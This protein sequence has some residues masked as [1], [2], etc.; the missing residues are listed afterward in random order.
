MATVRERTVDAGGVPIFFREWGDGRP[1]VL[2]HGF[3]QTSRCW[4]AVAR[5]LDGYRVL[6]PDIP[7]CGRS[8]RPRS[9]DTRALA[10]TMAAFMDA[11]G[12]PRATV[13][14]HD[15]GGAVAL[16]MGLYRPDAVERLCIVNSPYG[17][18]DL[19]HGWHMLLFNIPLLPELMFQLTRGAEVDFMLK[20]AAAKKDAF[21]PDAIAEYR[22]AYRSL[23][24][25]RAALAYYRTIT[26]AT[27]RRRL[28]RKRPS[29]PR[30]RIDMP[31]MVIWGALDPA[32]PVSLTDGIARRNPD[33]RIEKIAG[34]G[35]FVPEEA[36]E[37]VAA[38]LRD[39]LS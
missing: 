27:I 5:R 35:H 26:R 7:G 36:P 14:G 33:A 25:Q 20:R 11:A 31:L 10:E 22:G 29:G 21:E 8:G 6:A 9:F 37:E 12:A 4:D 18:L 39:F 17:E 34:A 16:A 30:R 23:E 1:V 32:L 28:S 24:R 15:L 3:P 38:L 19:R 2:L 13:V